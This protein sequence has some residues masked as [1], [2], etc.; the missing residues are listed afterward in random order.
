MF[1]G[2][3]EEVLVPEERAKVELLREVEVPPIRLTVCAV[4]D[5]RVSEK[6]P[7][8]E[9]ELEELLTSTELGFAEVVE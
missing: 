2:A 3:A 6:D 9:S 4:E 1:V 7:D 8:A 5:V